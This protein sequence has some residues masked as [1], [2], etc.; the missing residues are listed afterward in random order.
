MQG[1]E[2]GEELHTTP[3]AELLP[4]PAYL[5][6]LSDKVEQLNLLLA[7][8]QQQQ[9]QQTAGEASSSESAVA[10]ELEVLYA[11]ALHLH[12]TFGLYAQVHGRKLLADWEAEHIVQHQQ[13]QQL[14]P[15]QHQQHQQHQH[16]GS[17]RGAMR[18]AV[19]GGAAAT[20]AA[21]RMARPPSKAHPTSSF[22]VRS[23]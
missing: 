10:A 7:S 20:A 2:V 17:A 12:R 1:V 8:R 23:I 13:I 19:G 15:Q 11:A 6:D 14:P 22:E 5:R 9:V 21:E 4:L 18:A 3:C 16:S